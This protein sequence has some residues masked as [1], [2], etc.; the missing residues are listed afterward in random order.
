LR[1]LLVDVNGDGF[2]VHLTGLDF[3]I[4][5]SAQ[6]TINGVGTSDVR[7]RL[8]PG[9]HGRLDVQPT[10]DQAGQ[11]TT[12]AVPGCQVNVPWQIKVSGHWASWLLNG[13]VGILQ[14]S[15]GEKINGAICDAVTQN[16]AVGGTLKEIMTNGLKSHEF[17]G[18]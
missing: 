14:R 1:N 10:L 3:E 13:L 11:I 15:F 6:L 2:S 17:A 7:A 18:R 9:L 5:C 4:T 12:V 8:A 16:N